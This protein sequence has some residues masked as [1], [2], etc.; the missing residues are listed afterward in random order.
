[1][2]PLSPNPLIGKKTKIIK[3][4]GQAKKATL[5]DGTI[6]YRASDE[7][8]ETFYNEEPNHRV[9]IAPYD[10]HFCYNVPEKFFGWQL[11]CTCGSQAGIVGASAYK[12]QG[13][14]STGDGLVAGEMVVCLHHGRYGRH[15]DGSS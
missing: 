10:N 6:I 3:V 7:V 13:S 8:I 4:A 9:R 11:M 5:F 1:M 14:A 12:T 2:M 15:A